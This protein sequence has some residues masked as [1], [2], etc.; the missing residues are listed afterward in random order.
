MADVSCRAMALSLR[1][2]PTETSRDEWRE[3]H[4]AWSRL[5]QQHEAIWLRRNRPGG[6]QDSTKRFVPFARF[7]AAKAQAQ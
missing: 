3:L 6:L 7:L 4:D 2:S 1:E 5:A